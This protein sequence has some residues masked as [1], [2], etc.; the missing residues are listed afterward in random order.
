VKEDVLGIPILSKPLSVSDDCWV[1][2]TVGGFEAGSLTKGGWFQC[3]NPPFRVDAES[4]RANHCSGSQVF[5]Y[6]Q[7]ATDPVRVHHVI[8]VHPGKILTGCLF[9]HLIQ[10]DIQPTG[11]AINA[12]DDPLVPNRFHH[13]D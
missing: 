12:Q 2:K 13:I 3:T 6:Q 9:H 8:G 5:Q 1:V 11:L 10:A 4:G 7:L